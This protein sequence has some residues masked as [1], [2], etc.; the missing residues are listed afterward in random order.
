ML[1]LPQPSA[2]ALHHIYYTQLCRVV[3]AK[4]FTPEVVGLRSS[5][6]STVLGIYHKLFLTLKT[7]PAKSHYMFN[8]RDISKVS[9]M[10]R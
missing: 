2:Q 1:C 10:V 6:I 8:I 7:T 5:I 4:E 3:D 9:S